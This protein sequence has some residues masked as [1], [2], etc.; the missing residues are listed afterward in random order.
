[1]EKASTFCVLFRRLVEVKEESMLCKAAGTLRKD[2][3]KLVVLND[4]EKINESWQVRGR[5][6]RWGWRSWC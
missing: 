3:V 4:A 6:H 5:G 2:S 1:M